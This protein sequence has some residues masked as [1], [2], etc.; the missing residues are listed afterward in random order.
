MDYLLFTDGS[1]VKNCKAS[2]G[3]L[4]LYKS[5]SDTNY[6]EIEFYQKL[7]NNKTNNRAE[8]L[9]MITGIQKL[10]E[11]NNINSIKIY[12]DSINTIKSMTEWLIVWKKNGWKT[13]NRKPVKN[14]DLI[15]QLDQLY[16]S[17]LLKCSNTTIH[18]VYSHQKEP[19]KNDPN[20]LI[21]HGNNKVDTNIQKL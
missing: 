16:S 17:L 8:L 4:I 7:E 19:H 14:I 6:T 18:H 1:C 3:F 2:Y 13:A 12:S 11:F 15:Q 5:P 9:G 21:W 20:W 10:L